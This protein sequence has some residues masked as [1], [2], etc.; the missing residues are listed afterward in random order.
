MIFFIVTKKVIRRATLKLCIKKY[1]INVNF[2]TR[3]LLENSEKKNMKEIFINKK[4]EKIRES[5][6]LF[7]IKIGSIKY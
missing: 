4:S 1:F 5:A 7:L 3:N 6:H 2:V